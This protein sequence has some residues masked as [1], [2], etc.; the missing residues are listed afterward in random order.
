MMLADFGDVIRRRAE[1]L[2]REHRLRIYR[3]AD[4]LFAGLMLL[5]WV[6]AILA[7]FWISPLTWAGRFSHTHIHV[8]AAL[9]LG[10]AITL[11]PACLALFRPGRAS[12]R[13]VVASGQVLMSGL[14]IHLSGGRIE[15]HFHVFGSL[16]F[17]AFYR[18]WTVFI[19][20]TVLV[21]ADHFLRGV[22]WP[23]SVYG[24]LTAGSWRWLEHA[25]WVL[26]EDAFLIN[27]CLQSLREMRDIAWQRAELEVANEKTEQTVVIRTGE[28]KASEERFRSLSAASPIGIFETDSDGHSVYVNARWAEI[29]GIAPE[30][31]LGDGWKNTIH[32][33][34][35]DRVVA[36][37]AA[38]VRELREVSLEMRMRTAQGEVRWVSARSKPLIGDAG[39]V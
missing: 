39:R 11:F 24:V 36:E 37:W 6:A 1:E 7:A 3:R 16:A 25:G 23:Q 26:F 35:R 30:E 33:D 5:Q 8:W 21:A 10:G 12:T 20:A 22:Y 13:Y 28:F 31:A 15:T 19:P 2:F 4:R 9:F 14:L 18:D 27:A 17:L 34:D 32:P 29:A 38:A